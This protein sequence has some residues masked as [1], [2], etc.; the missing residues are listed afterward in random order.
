MKSTSSFPKAKGAQA[1]EEASSG[2]QA[3]PGGEIRPF[4]VPVK[5][6]AISRRS[7][8]V[9]RRIGQAFYAIGFILV[10]AAI[11]H[12]SYDFFLRT[13]YFQLQEIQISGVSE[14]VRQEIRS[15]VDGMARK[16]GSN[17]LRVDMGS[18]EKLISRH[19]RIYN[20]DLH[21]EY[22]NTLIIKASERDPAMLLASGGGV[23]LMDWDSHVMQRLSSAELKNKDLPYVTGIPSDDVQVGEKVYN[24]NVHQA[25]RLT[26]VLKEHNPDFYERL[27]EVQISS[28]PVSHIESLTAHLKGGM[29]VRFG[30]TNPVDALPGFEVWAKTLREQGEDPFDQAYCDLRFKD[31]IFH[32]DRKT[33]L[34]QQTGVLNELEEER[35]RQQA[36]GQALQ[37][38]AEKKVDSGSVTKSDATPEGSRRSPRRSAQQAPQ[39]VPYN[40]PSSQPGLRQ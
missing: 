5:G 28:D 25:L 35:Y 36:A 12:T 31:R 22:P 33:W 37:K 8:L 18:L 23:Y 34:A 26:R 27:S 29:E 24:A 13:P 30:D 38:A 15:L 9:R 10:L 6:R 20:L 2:A 16:A 4:V 17:I 39:Q 1:P 19:P 21:K 3:L 7:R 14:P 40:L 32:M 11:G